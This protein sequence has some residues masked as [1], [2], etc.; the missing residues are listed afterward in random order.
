MVYK[1]CLKKVVL[2]SLNFEND[3]GHYG[4]VVARHQYIRFL[5]VFSKILMLHH[6]EF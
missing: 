3:L 2:E 1:L 6:L 4:L 5:F